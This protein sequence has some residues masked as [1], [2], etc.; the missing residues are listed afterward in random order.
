M[1]ILIVALPPSASLS[2]INIHS[3]DL[4]SELTKKQTVCQG[5]NPD[6]S[7][8]LLCFIWRRQAVEICIFRYTEQD[9]N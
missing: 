6:R 9:T 3:L 5:I 1:M 4:L 2:H 7:V 8:A